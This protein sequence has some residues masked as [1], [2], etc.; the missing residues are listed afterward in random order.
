MSSPDPLQAVGGDG[1]ASWPIVAGAATAWETL[2][3]K[4]SAAMGV[5]LSKLVS[6]RLGTLLSASDLNL[7]FFTSRRPRRYDAIRG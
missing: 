3:S 5:A 6:T 7:S 4:E 1:G 2:T